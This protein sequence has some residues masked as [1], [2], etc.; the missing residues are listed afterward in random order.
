MR[1]AGSL[2]SHRRP[3]ELKL[4]GRAISLEGPPRVMGVLNI[5]PDSFSDGG[6]YLDPAEAERRALQ[7]QSEGAHL[8]DVGGESSRPG[9]RPVS[10]REEL[11][12][13]VPV[14]KR[15]RGRINPPVSIDTCKYDIASAAFDNGAEILNDISALRSDR[16]MARLVARQKAA[17]V[18]MH[19]RG[20]PRTMQDDTRYDDLVREIRAFLERAVERALE[21]GIERERIVIDPGFGFGKNAAQNLEL[22]ARLDEFCTLGVPVLVGVSR[23]S[24]IGQLLDEPA[25]RRLSGSLASAVVAAMKGASI[26]RAHDVLAHRQALVVAGAVREV[27]AR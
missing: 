24:F 23:K 10:V 7:L 21:A 16:R 13:V 18:L 14:L 19:L 9:S 6:R 11:K 15:L 26:I 2:G 17:V 25:D 3:L 1:S 5:T 22:L 20:E 4:P 12:R 8:I 27:G